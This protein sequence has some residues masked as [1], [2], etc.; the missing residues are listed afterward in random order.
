MHGSPIAESPFACFGR[1]GLVQKGLMDDTAENAPMM[2]GGDRN[3]EYRDAMSKV[4]RS[5]E[6]VDN[7]EQLVRSVMPATFFGQKPSIG[8]MRTKHIND[9]ALAA[10]IELGHEVVPTLFGFG[11]M[12]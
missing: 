2:H 1:K 11:A 4:D 9:A 10:V 8:R 12:C 3:A 7:P 5:V 6:R